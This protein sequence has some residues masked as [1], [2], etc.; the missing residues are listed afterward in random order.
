MLAAEALLNAPHLYSSSG[1][2]TLP[3]N[4]TPPGD[5]E[6]IFY[7]ETGFAGEWIRYTGPSDYGE[8]IVRWLTDEDLDFDKKMRS[9]T[10][11]KHVML[12]LCNDTP[13]APPYGDEWDSMCNS[14]NGMSTAG[15]VWDTD[16]VFDIYSSFRLQYYDAT[17]LGAVTVFQN[18][19]CYSW[20]GY[21]QTNSDINEKAYY[22]QADLM[23]GH[24]W[25]D[26]AS[27]IMVPYGYAAQVFCDDGFG[28][29]SEVIT[30]KPPT[31]DLEKMVC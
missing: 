21:F 31:D 7:S 1:A 29:A 24:V 11:G 13:Y 28:G 27:S 19:G 3:P 2:E 17:D 25:D 6:C 22:S 26:S 30:G 23:W 5:Y 18:P 15:A 20:S 14:E 16:M 12:E 4:V 8:K 9:F 10:C